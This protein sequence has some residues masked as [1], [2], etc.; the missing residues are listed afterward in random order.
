VPETTP[1]K[2]G[3][4][5]KQELAIAASNHA[6]TVAASLGLR[7]VGEPDWAKQIVMV[8]DM[9]RESA[10]RYLMSQE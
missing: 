5:Q 8:Y 3:L 6:A 1:D 4:T 7:I 10:D 9:V 2:I